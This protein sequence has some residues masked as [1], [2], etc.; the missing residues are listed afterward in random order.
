MGST[1]RLHFDFR[2]RLHQIHRLHFQIGLGLLI[3]L[4]FLITFSAT[5]VEKGIFTSLPVGFVVR[6][7]GAQALCGIE[8]KGCKQ[9]FADHRVPVNGKAKARD[10]DESVFV[11]EQLELGREDF[12]Q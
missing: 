8:V 2:R 3:L 6:C 4:L 11:A 5:T 1:A 12:G 10:L 7:P 9:G